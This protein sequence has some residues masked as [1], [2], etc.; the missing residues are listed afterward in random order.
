M[1]EGEDKMSQENNKDKFYYVTIA[2]SVVLVLMAATLYAGSVGG[3]DSD[4]ENTIQMNGNAEMMVVPDT[5]TLNIGAEVMAPTAEEASQ[6]NAVIMNAVIEELKDLGLEKEDIRTSRVS[7]RPE[8]NYEEGTRTI[9]GYSASNSVQITTTNLDI[10]GEMIDRS[11]SAGA[12][13]IGGISFSVSDEKQKEL[14]EDLITEAV[15]DASSK[16][17]VLAENLGVEIVG[18]KSSSISD[19]TQPRT[20]YEESLAMGPAVPAPTPIEPGESR[21]SMSVRVTY[22]VQ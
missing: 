8:Y 1:N 9:E 4:S 21:V 10:L 15:A 6:E 18:V 7:V 11:A 5:A 3:S 16:A 12:N 19:G 13:Q 14:H 20:Y 17:E 2:L 22:I